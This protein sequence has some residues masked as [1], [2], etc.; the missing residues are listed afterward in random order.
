AHN[1]HG[2]HYGEDT[3]WVAKELPE[4]DRAIYAVD[5]RTAA[6]TVP[7]NKGRESMA[8]LTYVI[9]RY[10]SLPEYSIFLHAHQKGYPKVWHNDAEQYDN[11]QAVKRLRL[12][13]VKKQGY[14]NL[15]CVWI[16]GCP[17][18]IQPFRQEAHRVSEHH[19]GAVWTHFFGGDNSTIS[20]RIGSTCCSQ[21]AITSERILARPKEDYIKFRQWILDTEL[22]DA[23][24]GRIMEYFWHIIFG[25]EA[26]DCPE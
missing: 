12:E 2:R 26:V 25:K 16:P 17:D 1:S 18:E 8:Y 7:K 3:A 15:S 5:N 6:L 13:H 10:D 21:F 4:W 22:D 20:H 14:V 19:A 9:D 23:V 11:V 24:S